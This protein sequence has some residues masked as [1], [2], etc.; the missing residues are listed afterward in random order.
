MSQRLSIEVLLS[1]L[2]SQPVNAHK[3]LHCPTVTILY[4]S[5]CF[6]SL[7]DTI[8]AQV[9]LPLRCNYDSTGENPLL[10]GEEHCCNK[11]LQQRVRKP[12]KQVIW[13]AKCD[14]HSAVWAF[15]WAPSEVFQALFFKPAKPYL[16]AT[17][18]LVWLYQNVC[19]LKK[20]HRYCHSTCSWSVHCY[21]ERRRW[22]SFLSINTLHFQRFSSFNL[23]KEKCLK[24]IKHVWLPASFNGTSQYSK[25]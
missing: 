4:I 20:T 16:V 11:S 12:S 21:R 23:I 15:F 8:H 25:L 13:N 5:Q 6:I 19:H 24:V 1:Q 14:D 3:R 9:R 18:N 17:Q 22:F 2:Q 7:T 10:L